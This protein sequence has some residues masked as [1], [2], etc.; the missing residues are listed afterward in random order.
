M[1]T[2]GTPPVYKASEGCGY[3]KDVAE[4]LRVAECVL[5]YVC[6]FF[7]NFAA[8]CVLCWKAWTPPLPFPPF[9]FLPSIM[10]CVTESG[11]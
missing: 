4:R 3:D 10:E 8:C 6:I 7:F 1:Q 11:S 2:S 9:T 5:A